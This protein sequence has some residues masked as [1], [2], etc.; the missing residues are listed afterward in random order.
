MWFSHQVGPLGTIVRRSRGAVVELVHSAEE[1]EELIRKLSRLLV[2]EL[3]IADL[4]RAPDREQVLR[5][6]PEVLEIAGSTG[7][8]YAVI[9]LYA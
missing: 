5:I 1:A 3:R 7:A 4:S 8:R 6:D 2:G 9:V